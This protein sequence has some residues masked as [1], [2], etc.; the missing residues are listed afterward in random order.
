[1]N[2]DIAKSIDLRT[3]SLCYSLLLEFSLIDTNKRDKKNQ[4]FF[5][6]NTT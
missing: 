2:L 3:H 4:A 5:Q 1:M 6:A